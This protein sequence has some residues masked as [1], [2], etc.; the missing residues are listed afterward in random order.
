MK[1]EKSKKQETSSPLYT[2][3]ATSKTIR[4]PHSVCS[5]HPTSLESDSSS[6]TQH[7]KQRRAYPTPTVDENVLHRRS[8]RE[9]IQG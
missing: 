9:L 4:S 1:P 7:F 6:L 3:L 5:I 8:R 2:Q